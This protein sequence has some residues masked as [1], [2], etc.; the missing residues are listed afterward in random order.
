MGTA[1]ILIVSVLLSFSLSFETDDS[2]V[3]V[4]GTVLYRNMG[5]ILSLQRN[6]TVLNSKVISVTVKPFPRSLLTPLE[7]EFS[8]L[9]NQKCVGAK[10]EVVLLGS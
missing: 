4:V 2:S 10:K 9:Y 3:F 8:H 7:I 6:S 5:N 1:D